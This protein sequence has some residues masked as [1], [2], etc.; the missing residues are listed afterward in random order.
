MFAARHS[1]GWRRQVIVSIAGQ[2]PVTASTYRS[3]ASFTIVELLTVIAIVGVLVSITIGITRGVHQRSQLG[4]AKADLAALASA[5]ERYKLQYGDYP[6]TPD[7]G[8]SGAPDGGAVLFNALVG[9]I[10]PKGYTSLF[11]P[12]QR[13]FVELS[14][15]TLASNAAADLPASGPTVF[16]TNWFNDPWGKWYYYVYRPKW[17]TGGS[18]NWDSPS[19]LLYSHG[20][21]GEC[22]IGTAADSG[23]LTDLPTQPEQREANE[24]NLYAGRDT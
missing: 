16:L 3:R 1:A 13:S 22:F 9:N 6:W 15:F 12:R 24:D 2:T 20:P 17:A 7:P 10:G 11:D 23:L 18:P 5:L 14:R 4:R 19:Y 21:D 8:V